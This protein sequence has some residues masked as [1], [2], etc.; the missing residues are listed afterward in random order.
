MISVFFC[1]INI[2]RYFTTNPFHEL[3][4]EEMQVDNSNITATLIT[5]IVYDSKI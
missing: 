2:D 3:L 4:T 1:C 5:N